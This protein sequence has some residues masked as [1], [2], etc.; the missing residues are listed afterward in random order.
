MGCSFRF[1]LG[2]CCGVASTLMNKG[3]L[4]SLN[5]HLIS[6][7]TSQTMKFIQ[8][9]SFPNNYWL[10]C[11][12]LN[13]YQP[14][15]QYK[16]K[17]HS[18]FEPKDETWFYN[19]FA[20][21]RP[22][23]QRIQNFHPP[24]G[25]LFERLP[26]EIID[27]IFDYV[28]L[29]KD[30]SLD[31]EHRKDME[32]H[33]KAEHDALDDLISLSL[34]S[35]HLWPLLLKRIH[36]NYRTNWSGKKV[37]FHHYNCAFTAGQAH[38][39]GI[40][41]EV[42]DRG[43]DPYLRWKQAI[44]YWTWEHFSCLPDMAWRVALIPSYKSGY[45]NQSDLEPMK[46]E[47]EIP[48][49]DR[50]KIEQDLRRTNLRSTETEWVLRN[51][52]TRQYVRS[53]RLQEPASAEPE[54]PPTPKPPQEPLMI[55]MRRQRK[56]LIQRMK[57]EAKK[58]Y[59]SP[60]PFDLA[61]LSLTLANIFLVLTCASAQVLPSYILKDDPERYLHFHDAPWSG[62]AFELIPLDEHM[63]AQERGSESSDPT[64]GTWMDV[65][66]EVV[67]DIANLRFCI[68]KCIA[69]SEQYIGRNLD[70]AERQCEQPAWHAY[71]VNHYAS[72]GK[73][74]RLHRQWVKTCPPRPWIDESMHAE[75]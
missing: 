5:L 39:Y 65:T 15:T 40:V 62:C 50:E 59:V 75:T 6:T 21:P 7:D 34:S 27:E 23:V 26:N 38:N 53:D 30:D 37:G 16:C 25:D 52:T 31:L 47:V 8:F 10:L 17:L 22:D 33:R 18:L 20:K 3:Q 61:D 69:M 36:R 11:P 12:E 48:Q 74:R 28:L 58:D 35:A 45:S 64:D 19:T 46:Y 42:G 70:T 43:G 29:H 66:R 49:E 71:W 56:A 57:N 2:L 13:Q 32:L 51:L 73:T 44:E 24:S 4:R 55:K 14:L 54:W 41:D 67:A 60:W 9:S 63:D 72:V 1:G 68:K